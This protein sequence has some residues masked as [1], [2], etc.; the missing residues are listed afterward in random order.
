MDI[1][2]ARWQYTMACF[3]A[4]VRRHPN[5]YVSSPPRRVASS[6]QKLRNQ[7]YGHGQPLTRLRVFSLPSMQLVILVSTAAPRTPH[8]RSSFAMARYHFFVDPA[9]SEQWNGFDEH[10]ECKAAA[11]LTQRTRS[12]CVKLMSSPTRVIEHCFAQHNTPQPTTS[13]T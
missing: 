9:G 13:I 5:G 11:H 2:R 4:M 6:M 12:I 10:T 3:D 8:R 1:E 7:L